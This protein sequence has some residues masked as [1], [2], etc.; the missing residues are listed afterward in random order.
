MTRKVHKILHRMNA[1]VRYC[2]HFDSY[3]RSLPIEDVAIY[4]RR[5]KLKLKELINRNNLWNI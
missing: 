5:I 2:L 3:Q 4:K 1:D